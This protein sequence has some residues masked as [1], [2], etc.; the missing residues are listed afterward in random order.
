MTF[1]NNRTEW[2]AGVADQIDYWITVGTNA[3]IANQYADATGHAPVMLEWGLG[4]WQC[5]LR[6]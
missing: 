6:Y 4:F 2:K 3:Q 1:G 5:K